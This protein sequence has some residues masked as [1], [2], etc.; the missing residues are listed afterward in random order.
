MKTGIENKGMNEDQEL[1]AVKRDS[2]KIYF[3]II[4]IAALLA[5]NI[6]FYVKFKSSGEKLYTVTLQKESL[7]S[8]IDR[9][10][11]ELD[12]I[13]SQS[14]GSTPDFLSSEREA[15]LKIEELRNKLELGEI[16][17]Q[18]IETAKQ[19]VY[20]LKTSV[21]RMKDEVTELRIKN[22]LLAEANSDLKG[23]LNASN[24]KSEKISKDHKVLNEKVNKASSIKVSNIHIAGVEEKKGGV[25]EIETKSKRID[26]LQVSFTIADNPLATTGKKDVYVRV[27]NPKGNL[28]A[29]SEDIFYVHGEKLQYSFKESIN[30][31]NN[32]QEYLMNWDNNGQ[33]F[34][35]G[36]YTILLYADNSIMGRA[37]IVLK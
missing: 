24:Q 36:A 29:N 7:Q 3:F 6:Y 26:K 13:K 37:S 2:S 23:E 8:E 25:I 15:R 10:E 32:G 21:S 20:Q 22:E 34:Q 27:I 17:D 11:A 35:K 12:N 5:T 28:E 4:A 9:I 18:Q 14:N 1:V 16:T 19:Q 30:F 31:T 33:R